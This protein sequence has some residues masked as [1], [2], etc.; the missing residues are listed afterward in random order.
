MPHYDTK[1]A[2][3]TNINERAMFSLNKSVA[4]SHLALT[5]GRAFALLLALTGTGAYGEDSKNPRE[6]RGD[7]LFA[8]Q[9]CNSAGNGVKA[10]LITGQEQLEAVYSQLQS[11]MLSAKHP[12]PKLDFT[13]ESVLFV[14]MG[15]QRTGGYQLA[16]DS[17]RPIQVY[18]DHTRITVTWLEPD[19]DTVTTQM[20]TT[21]C[22]LVRFPSGDYPALQIFDQNGKQRFPATP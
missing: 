20:L 17:R 12:V 10:T 3:L 1:E 16:F 11:N 8:S 9:Q 22:L 19:K 21:P 7:I 5:T 13:K 6:L 15:Q 2:V 14:E 4:T 18:P